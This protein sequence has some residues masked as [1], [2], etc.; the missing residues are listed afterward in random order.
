[1]ATTTKRIKRTRMTQRQKEPEDVFM[2]RLAPLKTGQVVNLVVEMSRRHGRVSREKKALML[3]AP[4]PMY[5]MLETA[6]VI[7]IVGMGSTV[8]FPATREGV[9][10]LAKAGIPTT[11]IVALVERLKKLYGE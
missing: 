2:R 4:G 7:T 10:D 3:L 11:L 1:M 5:G 8:L 6:V 9:S